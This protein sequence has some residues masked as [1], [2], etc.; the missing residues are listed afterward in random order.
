MELM[1][2]SGTQ[3]SQSYKIDTAWI[4]R[5]ERS[6]FNATVHTQ[7]LFCILLFSNPLPNHSA[8]GLTSKHSACKKLYVLDIIAV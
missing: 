2:Q 1:H 4:D 5:K 7:L 8:L 6:G 3:G